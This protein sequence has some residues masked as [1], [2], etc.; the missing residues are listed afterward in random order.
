MKPYD[1]PD[2]TNI[3]GGPG[4]QELPIRRVKAQHPLFQGVEVD[5]YEIEY[6]FEPEDAK[7]LMTKG[8][9]LRI[10]LMS[11]AVIPIHVDIVPET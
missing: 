1:M 3:A 10:C 6:E 4:F 9:R 5:A 11:K 7:Q 8:G 2:R